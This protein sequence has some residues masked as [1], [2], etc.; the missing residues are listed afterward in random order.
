MPAFTGN[1]RD[2][3]WWTYHVAQARNTD[4]L[5]EDLR[6]PFLEEHEP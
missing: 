6:R 3:P 5:L 1:D 4:R 2:D